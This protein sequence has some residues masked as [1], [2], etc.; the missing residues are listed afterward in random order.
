MKYDLISFDLQGTLSDNEFSD[1]F[2]LE[3]LP[4]IYQKTQKI[5]TLDQAKKILKEKFSRFGKYD[6]RYYLTSY[7]IK[8]LKIKKTEEQLINSISKKRY[9]LKEMV[10]II[11]KLQKNSK[12]IILSSTT[13]QFIDYELQDF[14][15]IF[16]QTYSS[17]EDL[18]IAG[19]PLEVF[20]KISKIYKILPEKCINIGD[21]LEMD[22]QNANKAGWDSFFWDR[23]QTKSKLIKDLKTKLKENL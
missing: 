17:I 10:P 6:K 16:D 21:S 2:W 20:E 12:V 14:K 3:M 4:A 13:R 7:W 11:K 9:F 19:K 23:T 18:A 5:K 22:I 1:H 8:K 15:K